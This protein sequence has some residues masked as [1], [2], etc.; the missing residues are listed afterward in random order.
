MGKILSP[1]QW[2]IGNN[3]K[4]IGN[5]AALR[6]GRAPALRAYFNEKSANKI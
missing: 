5:P 6:R 4:L 2:T 1:S 3:F